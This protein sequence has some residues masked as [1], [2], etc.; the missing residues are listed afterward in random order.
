MTF[1]EY[2]VG[3][4]SCLRT[5][6]DAVNERHF[7]DWCEQRWF[8]RPRYGFKE[9]IFRNHADRYDLLVRSGI[10]GYPDSDGRTDRR[11]KTSSRTA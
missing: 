9:S 1:D 6:A 4:V 7:L 5:P 8:D 2:L 10:G 3:V 11:H